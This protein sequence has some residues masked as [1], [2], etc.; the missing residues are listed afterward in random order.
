ML[1]P[2]RELNAGRST[3]HETRILMLDPSRRCFPEWAPILR[4]W[5]L[6]PSVVTSATELMR[7]AHAPTVLLLDA[8]ASLGPLGPLVAEW[9]RRH[10]ACMTLVLVEPHQSREASEALRLGAVDYLHKPF[11][12]PQLRRLLGD[13]LSLL[14][15]HSD[16]VV[17]SNEAR[18]VI[19]LARRAASTT[20]SVLITGESGTGKERLAR[21]IHEHS[22]RGQG[23][24]VAINC[25]A[26]PENMIE[27][28]LFGFVKGA[29]TGA[30][31]GQCGKFELAQGGTLLLDE[32][33]ELS[34][35]MQ[36]KLLRVLQER[37]V[38]RLGSHH[39]VALDVRVIAASNRD[40]RSMVATGAFRQDLFYRLDVLPLSWPALRERP[41]DILPLAQHFIDKYA[42]GGGYRLATTAAQQMLAYAWPGNVRELENVIQRALILS[43][44]LTLLPEDLRLPE[45]QPGGTVP[46]VAPD[47]QA[48]LQASK[49][50]AEF[51]CVLE[52]LRRFHGHRTRTAEALGMTTRAL[53][54]KLAAMREEGID[55][56]RLVCQ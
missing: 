47:V 28:M 21:F 4:E 30:V 12:V 6:S 32:I 2:N 41:A 20:A 55:I 52:T 10:P 14:S 31:Q 46:M 18:K 26:I 40:L 51:Q 27:A 19:Q 44:G 25:A 42:P 53:R 34:L 13:L 16:L 43:R 5:G 8:G 3:A 45:G 48:S 49:K 54:Y 38:E 29:Y 56:D 33:G 9:H 17:S 50:Q 36:A 1:F 37:E 15:P 35:A 22:D 39:K 23:P 24:F 11:G 7:V